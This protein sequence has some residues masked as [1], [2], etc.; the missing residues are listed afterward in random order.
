MGRLQFN[1]FALKMEA[2]LNSETLVSYN[3]T[4]R[5]NPEDLDLNLN[6]RGNLKSRTTLSCSWSFAPI[7]LLP[8]LHILLVSLFLNILKLCFNLHS[9]IK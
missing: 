7:L 1:Y 9:P 2:A 8:L 5:H 6:P 3:N 4:R